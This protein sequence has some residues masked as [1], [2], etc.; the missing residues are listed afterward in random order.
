MV[1]LTFLWKRRSSISSGERERIH[2]RDVEVR[3]VEAEVRPDHLQQELAQER[4]RSAELEQR[5]AA[6]AKNYL[7]LQEDNRLI[8]ENIVLTE[9]VMNQ[10]R[11]EYDSAI[12][13]ISRLE[14]EII[15]YRLRHKA[16][17]LHVDQVEK[18]LTKF[19]AAVATSHRTIELRDLEVMSL[20]AS[21]SRP[22]NWLLIVN[23][24][25]FRRLRQLIVGQ[26]KTHPLFDYSY[27]LENY[28][29]VRETG[30]DPFVHY[31]RFGAAEGRNPNRF[32]DTKWY[33]EQY[34]D[35]RAADV[36]PLVHYYSCGASEGRDPHPLFS[37]NWYVEQHRDLN[38]EKSKALLH[39]LQTK[40]SIRAILSNVPI[41][42]H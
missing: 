25:A 4:G 24:K 18:K 14:H 38:G 41:S 10:L 29:D 5:L 22:V 36:N 16:L 7:G 20:R 15:S 28:P 8:C 39:Y 23:K 40:K 30:L 33:L 2:G 6:M 1:S 11:V 27:Y 19:A 35:V 3:L 34:P 13:H 17:R 21:L 42:S 12:Q 9:D 26:T 32:F 37:T 31:L